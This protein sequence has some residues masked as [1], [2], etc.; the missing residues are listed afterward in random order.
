[1]GYYAGFENQATGAPKCLGILFS[2]EGQPLWEMILSII[3]QTS[4]M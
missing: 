1:M 3:T 4:S 2:S